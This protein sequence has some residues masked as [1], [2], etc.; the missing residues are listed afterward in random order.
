MVLEPTTQRLV[1]SVASGPPLYTLTPQTARDVLTRVQRMPVA[2]LPA[3]IQD[4]LL[5]VGPT[6]ETRVRIV[7]PEGASGPLPVVMWFHGG[8]WVLGDPDSYDRLVREVA[9]GTR[10]AVGFVDYERSPEARYP[11]AIEQA[12]AAFHHVASRG[13]ELGLDPSRIALAGDSAGGNMVAVVS[14]LAKQRRGPQAAFLL[15][16]YPVT[17]GSMNRVHRSRRAVSSLAP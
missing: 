10:A 3:S 6:G 2:K 12:Y 8:G 5:P 11:V 13:A 7:R 14:L 9:E 16:Y 15:M 1:D 4:T 17:D